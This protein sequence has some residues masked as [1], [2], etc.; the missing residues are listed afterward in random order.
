MKKINH[1]FFV[2]CLS[3]LVLNACRP[4]NN[5]SI[6]QPQNRLTQ[7][8]GTWKLQSVIQTDLNAKSNNYMDAVRTDI[9]VQQMNI[10]NAAPFTDL[11][12]TFAEDAANT[13]TTFSVDYGAAPKIFK[14]AGGVWKVDNLLAP[15]NIKFINGVD[16]VSLKL[17]N[18]NNLAANMMTLQKI[19]YQGIKP[20]IQYDYNF[21]KN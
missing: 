13:P 9:N 4:D 7:L 6:G 2:I 20:K 12:L 1:F 5:F 21:I 8:A 16:T 10:T 17:G 11:K 18:V 14:S 19:K 15:G 3:A